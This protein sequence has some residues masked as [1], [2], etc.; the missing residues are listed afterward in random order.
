MYMY[1]VDIARVSQLELS[2]DSFTKT[3]ELYTLENCIE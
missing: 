3:T 2:S 1:D